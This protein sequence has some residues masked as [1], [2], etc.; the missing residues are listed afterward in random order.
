M[1]LAR[2]YVVFSMVVSLPHR[3]MHRV[4]HSSLS[5][6]MRVYPFC[7]CVIHGVCVYHSYVAWVW[8]LYFAISQVILMARC[9]R[10]VRVVLRGS[11]LACIHILSLS[12]AT[13]Y[14]GDVDSV[15]LLSRSILWQAV[16]KTLCV[17]C[18]PV[19][20]VLFHCGREIGGTYFRLYKTLDYFFHSTITFS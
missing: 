13:W 17:S 20:I 6:G 2:S 8:W 3:R 9:P 12:R 7:S 15:E 16:Y 5:M 18:R 11:L 1:A 14:R 10:G 4:L 19:P